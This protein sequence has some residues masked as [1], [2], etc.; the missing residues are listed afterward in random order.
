MFKSGVIAA[1]VSLVL[2]L[3]SALLSPICVPCL[4]LFLGFGA[5]L[6]AG[7]FDKPSTSGEA[8]KVGAIA[9]AIGGI[10][11]IAGQIVGAGLNALLVG[12]EAAA[13]IAEQL[14]IQ[15]GGQMPFGTGYWAGLVGSAVCFGVLDVVLMAGLGALGGLAWRGLAGGK[16][17]PSVTSGETNVPL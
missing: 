1:I 3:G 8:A 17:G 9:G 4:A 2:A 7:V 10:G 14:G 5:G 15:T 16:K 11:A 6:L 13:R 12:P